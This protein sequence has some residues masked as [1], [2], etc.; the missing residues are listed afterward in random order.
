MTE[1]DLPLQV[2]TNAVT[3]FHYVDYCFC[4]LVLQ[5]KTFA[6]HSDAFFM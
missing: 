1:V 2:Q 5:Q 4:L 3:S 6:K